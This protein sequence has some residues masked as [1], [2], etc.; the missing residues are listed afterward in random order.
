M[1]KPNLDILMELF[2]SKEWEILKEEI[3]ICRDNS[4][5][6]LK[7]EGEVNRE[8]QA[9]AVW[10][11]EVVIGLEKKYKNPDVQIGTSN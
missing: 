7:R 9:G 10:A 6:R 2:N 5:M 8:Y 4:M 3:G 11:Y 1:N